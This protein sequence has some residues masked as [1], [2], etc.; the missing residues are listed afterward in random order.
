[1]PR[2]YF[3]RD[4]RYRRRSR[5]RPYFIRDVR[6]RRRS[7]LRP[8]FIRGVR[9]RRRSRPRPYF[10]RYMRW[11]RDARYVRYVCWSRRGPTSYVTHVTY[12]TYV[13]Y[14]TG[15][16]RGAGRLRPALGHSLDERALPRLRHRPPSV[17]AAAARIAC[18]PRAGSRYIRFIRYN[19][20]IRNHRYI[21]YHRYIRRIRH[22]R[23]AC[24]PRVDSRRCA[25]YSRYSSYSSYSRYSRYSFVACP[26]AGRSRRRS[27]ARTGGVPRP[28]QDRQAVDAALGQRGQPLQQE[29]DRYRVRPS[30]R[31]FTP[32]SPRTTGRPTRLPRPPPWQYAPVVQ[33]HYAAVTVCDHLI[34]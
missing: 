22:I 30:H 18:Q 25:R 32:V 20:Y 29:R 6:Y 15:V 19:R 34:T 4:V 2:P 9:Y 21:R 13:T 14:V 12:A 17:G 11:T 24:Q 28:G 26:R 3:N 23:I 16:G 27:A 1:M 5:P 33:R 7:M 31:P 10:N 8:Y